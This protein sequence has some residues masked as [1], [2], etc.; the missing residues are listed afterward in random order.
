MAAKKNDS[1][2]KKDEL[3]A[4]QKAAIVLLS[5]DKADASRV[6]KNMNPQTL[7]KITQAIWSIGEVSDAD[8]ENALEELGKR[9]SSSTMLGGADKV[10]ELLVEVLGEEKARDIIERAKKEDNTR[11][12]FNSLV[13]IKSADLANFLN[14]EQPSTIAIVLGF[15]PPPK[16]GEILGAFES[17]LRH[18]VALRLALPKPAKQDIVQRIEK[19]F[20]RNIVSKIATKKDKD[21]DKDIGGPKMMAEIIQSL[22]R[23]TGDGILKSIQE[24][25]PEIGNEIAQQLF[26]FDDIVRFGPKEMQRL[27]RDVPME[28]LPMALRGVSETLFAKFADNLSK[29]A[30]EN[31][32]EEMQLMG[33]A[34]LADVQNAQ[35]EIVAIVRSLEAAGEIQISMGGDDD[36]V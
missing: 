35:R 10:H 19:V 1:K 18:E 16:V 32:A 2:D 27:M 22:D 8:R 14:K 34:K 15:L 20:V 30:R 4:S 9:I 26:T 3:T 24:S 13:H 28:K 31:L 25:Q 5:L 17:D 23:D 29:R 33:R 21:Q 6:M 7:E 12:A 11:K 36:Y